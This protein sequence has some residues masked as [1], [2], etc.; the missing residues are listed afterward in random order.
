MAIQYTPTQHA[1][2]TVGDPLTEAEH[3]DSCDINKMM[4]NA[5]KGLQVRGGSP[6]A[7]GEDD[8]TMDAVSFHIQKQKLEKGLEEIAAKHE[9][10]TKELDLIPKKVRDKYKF[11]TKNELNEQ[12]TE[13]PIVPE[14]PQ[15]PKTPST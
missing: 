11:K 8:L 10:E 2:Y 9:F 1:F 15:T 7:Y 5:L 14:T 6:P 4:H 13:L 12:K 3:A